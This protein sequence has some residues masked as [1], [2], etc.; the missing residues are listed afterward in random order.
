MFYGDDAGGA[1]I[2]INAKTVERLWQSDTHR[3]WKS[4]PMTYAIDGK[5]Y[6]GVV[7]EATVRVFGLPD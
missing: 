6:V 3:P 1:L 7:A 5:Q 4:S 2:A